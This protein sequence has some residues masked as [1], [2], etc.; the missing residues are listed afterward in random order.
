MICLESYLVIS[1]LQD[2]L[3]ER[4]LGV[5]MEVQV[6]PRDGQGCPVQAQLSSEAH[7]VAC[8][9]NRIAADA[10]C[11]ISLLFL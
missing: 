4:G 3:L 6:L 9:P 2:C 1:K 8:I 7:G 11:A 5:Q 10:P